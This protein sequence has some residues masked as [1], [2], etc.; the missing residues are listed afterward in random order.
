MY[1]TKK[2]NIVSVF[3]HY[4]DMINLQRDLINQNLSHTNASELLL[5]CEEALDKY[6]EFHALDGD[7]SKVN[8]WLGYIQG[9]LIAANITSVQKERDYTRPYLTAH[10]DE[11]KNATMVNML[12]G[13]NKEYTGV[14]S[15]YLGTWTHN[16]NVV[17]CSLVLVEY[18]GLYLGVSRKDD[19]NDISL[20]GGK[21]EPGESFEQAAVREVLE[22]TGLEVELVNEE[23]FQGMD[24]GHFCKTYRANVVGGDLGLKS[25]DET[26]MVGYY[27]QDRLI[28][29]SFGAYNLEMFRFFHG[30]DTG[31]WL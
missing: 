18:E 6:D 29:G 19:H 1:D 16:S 12:E 13:L 25:P 4:M 31:R 5:L 23:P 27:T 21:L 9:S 3:H 17:A 26:G 30:K 28:S 14:R 2:N 20:P 15:N 22:E 8:R 10:R 11:V 24:K 7:N